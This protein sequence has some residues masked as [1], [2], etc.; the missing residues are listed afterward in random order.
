MKN[1]QSGFTFIELLVV[2]TIIGIL[3]AIG[4]ASYRSANIRSRDTKR[5]ADMEQIRSA[6]EMYRADNST[7]PANLSSLETT[8]IQEVPDPPLTSDSP[9]QDGYSRSGTTYTLCQTLESTGT[10]YCVKNP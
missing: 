4:M 2:I 8:Y 5:K 3:A 7:Y 6:L 9:Y 1:K 10:S